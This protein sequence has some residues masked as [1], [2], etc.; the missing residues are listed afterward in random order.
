MERSKSKNQGAY[1]RECVSSDH[2]S[3]IHSNAPTW[4]IY[5]YKFLL[6]AQNYSDFGEARFGTMEPTVQIINQRL[7]Y[8]LAASMPGTN[9]FI[10]D[11]TQSYTQSITK[12]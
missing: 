10:R 11:I 1:R 6:V 7:V 8:A 9:P 2:V 5:I 3:S 12:L 4:E